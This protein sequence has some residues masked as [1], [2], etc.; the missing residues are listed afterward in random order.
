MTVEEFRERI[1]PCWSAATSFWPETWTEENPAH[2]QCLVTA[3]VARDVFG[4]SI[5]YGHIS[6]LAHY[7][8]YLP[9]LGEIDFTRSQ[10][11]PGPHEMV[12]I[13]ITT[14]S[15]RGMLRRLPGP[16]LSDKHFAVLNVDGDLE[17][18]YL[19]LKRRY[20]FNGAYPRQR[21]FKPFGE[22]AWG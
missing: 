13:G 16:L 20:A 12:I 4:G 5:V 2:G 9:R 21:D 15:E 6:G 7:W 19:L 3:L 1:E 14:P 17:R 11:G 8:N 22:L 10:F 18:R